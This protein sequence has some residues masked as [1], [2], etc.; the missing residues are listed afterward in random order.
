MMSSDN[1]SLIFVIFK[2]WLLVYNV[3]TIVIILMCFLN[4]INF[5][6]IVP[7]ECVLLSTILSDLGYSASGWF[8]EIILGLG[9]SAVQLKN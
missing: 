2:I 5:V 4:L 9:D 3:N 8:I 6:I 7:D 1:L